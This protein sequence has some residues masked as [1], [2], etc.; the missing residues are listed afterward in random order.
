M[1]TETKIQ[2]LESKNQELTRKLEEISMRMDELTRK[3][4]THTHSGIDGSEYLYN[5]DINLKPGS[6]F[7]S[8]KFSFLSL[9][10]PDRIGEVYGFLGL[11]ELATKSG[12]V[13]SSGDSSQITFD[14]Q[15][16]TNTSS[17]QTFL[18][19]NRYPV[20][21]G[22]LRK[23][24]TATSAGNTLTQTSFSF[25]TD[26]LAGAYLNIYNSSSV[27]QYTRQIAS[28]TS[29]VITIDGTF[30]STVTGGFFD[31]SM[32]IYFG[33]AQSP[34]RMGYFLGQDVSSGGDG[35]QRRVLRFG[36]GTT[37]GA[38]VIGVY[39]GTGSPESVVTANVGSLYLRTDGS[40]TTT[41][42]VKTSGTGNTGWTAK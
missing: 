21:V 15:G 34:W 33:S 37:A 28:N 25:E 22:S 17:N 1:D 41:L 3:Q 36:Y 20:Y 11:G 35:G 8:G 10:V 16:A 39:F 26:E 18:F 40:T 38:D 19:G 13:N 12:L 42:Y 5:D 9:E 14:H 23:P 4:E 31:I 7:A 29:T 6:G 24:V 27:F 30:P 32:P 2:E